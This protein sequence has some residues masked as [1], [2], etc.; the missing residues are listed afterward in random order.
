MENDPMSAYLDLL[1]ELTNDKRATHAIC[2]VITALRSFSTSVE[3]NRAEGKKTSI[4]DNPDFCHDALEILYSNGVIHPFG[5]LF[6]YSIVNSPC[7][8]VNFV[9]DG[10]VYV[11][12]DRFINTPDDIKERPIVNI[13]TRK[14]HNGM[15]AFIVKFTVGDYHFDININAKRQNNNINVVENPKT[16]I[17]ETMHSLTVTGNIIHVIKSKFEATEFEDI[18]VKFGHRFK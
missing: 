11:P 17:E 7:Y 2:A 3:F 4:F 16:I 13:D 6:V 10:K 9:L 1:L 5:M 18:E 8:D 12:N 14:G 15:C